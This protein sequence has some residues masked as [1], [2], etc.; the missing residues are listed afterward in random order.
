M[1]SPPL[2]N[3]STFLT[4]F[5]VDR[6]SLSLYGII[7]C[8]TASMRACHSTVI[9]NAMH[10]IHTGTYIVYFVLRQV[11][12]K[13]VIW[14]FRRLGLVGRF[15]WVFSND[16]RK[17][18]I[19]FVLLKFGCDEQFLSYLLQKTNVHFK[20]KQKYSTNICLDCRMKL[21]KLPS[22]FVFTT[23]DRVFYDWSQNGLE[24]PYG[25]KDRVGFVRECFQNTNL[26]QEYS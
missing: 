19:F 18:L 24:V 14:L 21:S 6:P 1:C 25:N 12:V 13:L 11:R 9:S 3:E 15:W 4:T 5:P 26:I 10:T 17:N 8:V 22:Y 7:C 2:N 20:E 23:V 16:K